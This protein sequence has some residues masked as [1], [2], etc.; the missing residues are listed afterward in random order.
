MEHL[1]SEV[2]FKRKLLAGWK[3]VAASFV[4]IHK[5]HEKWSILCFYGMS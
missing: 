5:I 4:E 1:L 2:Y 3:K